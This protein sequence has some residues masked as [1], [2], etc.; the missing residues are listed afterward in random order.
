MKNLLF[1]LFMV[2]SMFSLISCGDEDSKEV[3]EQTEEVAQEVVV[4]EAQLEN[5]VEEAQLEVAQKH[6][7]DGAYSVQGDIIWNFPSFL[8]SYYAIQIA[9][10]AETTLVHIEQRPVFGDPQDAAC[11]EFARVADGVL[12]DPKFR[13]RD[14]SDEGFSIGISEL[15][16]KMN[17]DNTTCELE[18]IY[19]SS[20]DNTDKDDMWNIVRD[21]SVVL[22]DY[23][24]LKKECDAYPEVVLDNGEDKEE[25]KSTEQS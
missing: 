13:K 10:S 1:S 3:A 23:E 6:C 4:E 25:E 7:I 2:F 5:I 15:S 21:T 12:K 20:P 24:S 8:T 19:A 17:K 14:S 11:S 9:S 22:V 16:I 18:S